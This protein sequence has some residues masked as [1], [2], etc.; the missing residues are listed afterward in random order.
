[1]GETYTF[2]EIILGNLNQAGRV[3]VRHLVNLNG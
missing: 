2:K 1:M 3:R